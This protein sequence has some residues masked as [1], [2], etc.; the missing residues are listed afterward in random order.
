MYAS[1]EVTN[2]G[3]FAVADVWVEASGFTGGSVT[4]APGETAWS[5]SAQWRPARARR[6]TSTCVA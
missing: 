3:G 5:S 6:R 1:Y 4:L 2:T